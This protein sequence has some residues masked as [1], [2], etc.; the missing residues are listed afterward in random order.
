MVADAHDREFEAL[1]VGNYKLK[2]VFLPQRKVN[3][4][5]SAMAQRRMDFLDIIYLLSN[6][7]EAGV[8]CG[9]QAQ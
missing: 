7:R 2:D 3:Q 8:F 5:P 1:V 6:R 9:F 4:I